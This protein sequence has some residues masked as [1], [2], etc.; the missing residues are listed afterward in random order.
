VD[1]GKENVFYKQ[2]KLSNKY[3]QNSD[4][5]ELRKNPYCLESQLDHIKTI[6]EKMV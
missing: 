2:A 6:R 4:E 3:A 5:K 1:H